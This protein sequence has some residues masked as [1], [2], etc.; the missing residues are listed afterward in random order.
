MKAELDTCAGCTTREEPGTTSGRQLAA[1]RPRR[2][3]KIIFTPETRVHISRLASLGPSTVRTFVVLRSS[4][5]SW[6]VAQRDPC[7][8]APCVLPASRAIQGTQWNL[9]WETEKVTDVV[10]HRAPAR[11]ALPHAKPGLKKV[12]HNRARLPKPALRKRARG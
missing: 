9:A 5:C 6:S 11:R 2:R 7:L 1:P 3:A 8:N 10:V 12:Q 4:I